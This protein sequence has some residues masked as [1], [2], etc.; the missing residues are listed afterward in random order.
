MCKAFR[1]AAV[2]ILAL[3]CNGCGN[4]TIVIEPIDAAFNQRLVTGKDLNPNLFSRKEIA[5][6]YQLNNYETLSPRNLKM[7]LCKYIAKNRSVKQ[8]AGFSEMNF[9]FYSKK[10]FKDYSANL[11]RQVEE[12]ES[13]RIDDFKD[14]L[15]GIVSFK[16]LDKNTERLLRNTT[17][18]DDQDNFYSYVD[19]LTINP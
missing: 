15:V 11:Y 2:I 12:S 5:Q 7:I 10:L 8:I 14:D 9:I 18:Y 13:G 19:T 6:Y 4:D 16:K 3:F 17:I 1:Y